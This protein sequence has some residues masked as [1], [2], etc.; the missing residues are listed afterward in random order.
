MSDS[1][2]L[3]AALNYASKGW[4]VFPVYESLDSGDC[5]CGDAACERSGKHPAVRWKDAAT[6]DVATITQWWSEHPSRNIGIATGNTSG[7]AV[8]DIDDATAWEQY[9][10]SLPLELR[11][12][13]ETYTVGTGSGG[14][15]LYFAYDS[16]ART[17]TNKPFKGVDIRSDGGYVV[18]PP[19]NHASGGSYSVLAD[20][21][22]KPF[23]RFILDAKKPL[24]AKAS[25]LTLEAAK[26]MLEHIPNDD[27]STWFSVGVAL[28]RALGRSEDGFELYSSWSD[29]DYD[30]TKDGHRLEIMR[31]AYFKVSSEQNTSGS[32]IDGDWL[33][34]TAMQHG[35]TLPAPAPVPSNGEL[36]F[37]PHLFAY[38]AGENCFVNS[39][40]GAK[41]QKAGINNTFG[42][43]PCN[44]DMVPAS[45][46][47]VQTATVH[48]MCN[49]PELPSGIVHDFALVEGAP[50]PCTGACLINTFAPLNVPLE[51][52]TH[53]SRWYS[54]GAMGL[55]LAQQR[56]GWFH[57]N[58]SYDP[59]GTCTPEVLA[60]L[61]ADAAPFL[62]HCKRLFCNDP[63]DATVFIDYMAFKYQHPN[64]KPRWALVIAGQQGVG[65]DAAIDA[66][67]NAYGTAFI[68]NISA[69]DL[70]SP[71]NDYLK[72]SLLRISEV[73]DLGDSNKWQFNERV[74]TIIAGHPDRTLINVKYGIKYWLTLA[75][76]TVLT[77]NHLRTGLFMSSDDRRY[78]VIGCA[79]FEQLGLSDPSHKLGYFQWLFQ[80]LQNGGYEAVAR[81]LMYGRDVR[82]FTPNKA[83]EA[84][85]A[86]ADVLSNAMA[87]D[88]DFEDAVLAAGVTYTTN[89]PAGLSPNA[90]VL[91]S[92]AP[93]GLP[94]FVH[95][96]AVHYD[97]GRGP[98]RGNA[99]AALLRKMGY[100]RI[101][102]GTDPRW[103]Y[104]SG[105]KRFRVTVYL[106]T[107][108]D[109]PTAMANA[110]ALLGY[111]TYDEITSWVG[112][113]TAF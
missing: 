51:P 99:I 31:S 11:T 20:L 105:D 89:K 78:Y 65:K 39:V 10:G 28:G 48:D 97:E 87:V 79:S 69:T 23:P 43:V 80:W 58:G 88:D 70:N 101:N 41:W 62:E 54:G 15:H 113:T 110:K 91:Y 24:V 108:T 2:N 53:P 95:P 82:A 40:N 26:A 77:T 30:G 50:V 90:D 86:K 83:P 13:L 57:P 94:F 34:H 61:E 29:R 36:T 96:K 38:H 55:A 102:C 92:L 68:S 45:T 3:K 25:K 93:N 111:V 112:T 44:G 67:W 42:A 103:Q 33:R 47:I 74:K 71:Y 12:A 59:D 37:G 98:V 107:P 49:T 64:L 100:Q 9:S 106:Y 72:C 14:T 60:R 109:E 8:I 5:A 75:N 21:P 7:L 56:G 73:A 76:G 1:T 22:L 32:N 66:C 84:T 16:A 46:Y 63:R 85:A 17:C 4:R 35:Y 19:S 104:V 27:F 18:A 81:Y 6:T 52:Q